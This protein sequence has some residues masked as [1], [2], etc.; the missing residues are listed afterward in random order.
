MVHFKL[1]VLVYRAKT[2]KRLSLSKYLWTM[3]LHTSLLKP[4]YI[5]ECSLGL[6]VVIAT[7]VIK[8][9]VK[10]SHQSGV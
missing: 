8:P 5:P 4:M 10:G 3:S 7:Y 6:Y 2:T 1:R 9:T